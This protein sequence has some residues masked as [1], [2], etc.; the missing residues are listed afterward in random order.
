MR[1]FSLVLALCLSAALLPAATIYSNTTNDLG[2]AD[3][4]IDNGVVEIGDDV[5][6]GGPAVLQSFTTSIANIT[7]SNINAKL[8][9]QIYRNDNGVLSLIGL[10]TQDGIPFAAGTNTSVTFSLGGLI[11]PQ[12]IVWT[13]QS[14]SD[15]LGIRAFSAPTVGTSDASTV[16]WSTNPA[17]PLATTITGTSDDYYAIIDGDAVPEPS[18]YAILISG[19]GYMMYRRLRK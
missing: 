12:N 10:F 8:G 17:D 11:A 9:L 16:Y 4:F 19:V 14:T 18:T 1:F 13:I 6:F 7:G 3:R 15:L 2:F 5:T